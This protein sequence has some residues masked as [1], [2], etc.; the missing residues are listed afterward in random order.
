MTVEARIT[1]F[2]P[3]SLA[4]V[5]NKVNSKLHEGRHSDLICDH[6]DL[7]KLKVPIG[8]GGYLEKRSHNSQSFRLRKRRMQEQ[9]APIFEIAEFQA[10][11]PAIEKGPPEGWFF[12]P[13]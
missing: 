7:I 1:L 9:I 8:H 4:I 2:K 12:L 10:Q 6:R 3:D 13:R 5:A 11:G